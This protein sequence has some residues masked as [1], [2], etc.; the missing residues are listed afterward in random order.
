MRYKTIIPSSSKIV[1]YFVEMT[2][3]AFPLANHNCL[4]WTVQQTNQSW[5]CASSGNQRFRSAGKSGEGKSQLVSFL[6]LVEN[7]EGDFQPIAAQEFGVYFRHSIETSKLGKN[8]KL[9]L[10]TDIFLGYITDGLVT[11]RKFVFHAATIFKLV[12]G[13]TWLFASLWVK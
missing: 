7:V 1:F 4:N 13:K 11:N 6:W 5:R 9:F 8:Q 3:K 12:P 10:L 2:T